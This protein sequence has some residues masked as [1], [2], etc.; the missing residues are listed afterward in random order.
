MAVRCFRFE[1]GDGPAV[2]TFHTLGWFAELSFVHGSEPAP[3]GADAPTL[4]LRDDGGRILYRSSTGQPERVSVPCLGAD[5]IRAEVTAS[6]PAPVTWMTGVS[7]EP[8]PADLLADSDAPIQTYGE[9]CDARAQPSSDLP[10]LAVEGDVATG[11]LRF[12]CTNAPPGASGTLA[13]ARAPISKPLAGG[14]RALVERTSS[15][16]LLQM[17]TDAQGRAE[18]D[19]ALPADVLPGFLYTQVVFRDPLDEHRFDA[20]TNGVRVQVP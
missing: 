2:A 14:C 10:R 1:P 12:L 13:I 4:T 9:G 15:T 18:L 7:F 16:I 3:D 19:V 11:K 17:Q 20:T 8:V 5:W 6:A